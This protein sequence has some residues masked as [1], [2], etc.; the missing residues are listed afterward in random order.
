MGSLSQAKTLGGVGAILTLLL[1]IPSGVGAA[2]VVL[3]W[4]LILLAI[5]NISDTLQDRSIYSKAIVSVILSIVGV[6]IFAVVVASAVLGF[7]GL[8]ATSSGPPP[9]SSDMV[10][11]I[12]GIVGGLAI[13][14]ILAIVSSYFLWQSCKVIAKRLNMGLFGTASLLFFI[15]AICTIVLVGFLLMLVAQIVFIIAF[16]SLPNEPPGMTGQTPMAPPAAPALASH[17]VRG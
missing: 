7:I 10:G 13:V 15:G 2:L 12:A 6:A 5:K 3:G 14:W 9:L 17:S 16:F 1:F 4:I 11:L 8:G